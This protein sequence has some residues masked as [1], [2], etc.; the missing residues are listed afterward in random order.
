MQE[1]PMSMAPASYYLAMVASS[2]ND[3]A[4]CHFGF[5]D[6]LDPLLCPQLSL[7]K[8]GCISR[9][10][11]GAGKLCFLCFMFLRVLFNVDAEVD[12]CRATMKFSQYYQ[13]QLP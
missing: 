2:S 12:H 4:M 11:L 3:V 7:T 1:H 6:S 10:V 13:I 9:S 5:F 8:F